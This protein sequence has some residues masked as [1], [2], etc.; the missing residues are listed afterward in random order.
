M[1]V[2]NQYHLNNH[3]KRNIGAFIIVLFF[4]SLACGNSGSNAEATNTAL[5]ATN[6][7]QELEFLKLTATAQANNA[8][9]SPV[10]ETQVTP[11]EIA[12]PADSSDN[13]D[14]DNT[15]IQ[16]PTPPPAPPENVLF[17]DDFSNNNNGW[18]LTT[19]DKGSVGFVQQ[20]L[21]I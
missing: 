5:Q 8:P 14:T 11:G 3:R 18:D 19:K 17:F 12:A 6:T 20:S 1:P 16:F 15:S 13:G 2:K 9:E 4:L 10:I 21:V 7:A